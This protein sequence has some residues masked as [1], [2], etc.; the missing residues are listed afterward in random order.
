MR[1]AAALPVLLLLAGCTAS[2]H[3]PPPVPVVVTLGD[4]V[5]A[6][7]ACGC[8]PFPAQYARAQHAIDV[9]LA[10]AGYTA[11]DVLAQMPADTPALANA[12]EVVIMVGANDLATAFAD[13]DP[14]APAA[15][16]MRA[17]V[18][19]TITAI[20]RIRPVPVIVL[21]YWNVVLDGQVGAQ[22]Y[23]PAGMRDA[24]E[25]TR[26]AN[27]ALQAAARQ[28]GAQF[29]PTAPA[30]HGTGGQQDATALL[31]SDGDHP[32]AAGHAAIAALLPPLAD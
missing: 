25:A 20:E 17:D 5:P 4:S 32:N 3:R 30:F 23:G 26:Y 16:T 19:A 29:V 6:G 22:M 28:S 8:E 18:V 15:A 10:E 7:T 27:E 12:A 31:A 24:A 13:E 2:A 9:N 21:G 14:Y 1:R 11:A